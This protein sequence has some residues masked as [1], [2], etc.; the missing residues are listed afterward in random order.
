MAGN[1]APASRA[2]RGVVAGLAG[3][4]AVLAT[5]ARACDLALVLA[6]DVSGSVDPAE[7]MIQMQGLAEALRDPVISEA[8]VRGEA[9]VSLVQWTG[10]SRQDLT[11]PWMRLRDF[12]AVEAFA[13]SVET[14]PRAWRMYSTAIGEALSFSAALF[15]AVPDCTRRVV[16]VS[17]DGVSNEGIEPDSLRPGLAALGV[18]VNALVI[19][20]PD[21]DLVEY[22]HRNVITGPGAF[23]IRANGFA[24]YPERIRRKLLR[25]VA[26]P[27]SRLTLPDRP[28][29]M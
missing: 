11:I 25:E 8:L 29:P 19:E 27:L 17:G 1:G 7:Y 28:Q 18:T 13:A 12:D 20:P 23:A 22:F 21:R 5:P 10:S 16:D 26:T 14:T 24:E 6:V 2:V 3:L 15:Q 9:A 4:A